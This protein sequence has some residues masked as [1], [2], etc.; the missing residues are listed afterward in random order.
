MQAIIDKKLLIRA[1]T[2]GTGFGRYLFLAEEVQHLLDSQRHEQDK[3]VAAMSVDEARLSLR[4]P[5]C[6]ISWVIKQKLLHAQ[7]RISS[8]RPAFII[9]ET[10]LV[11]FQQTYISAWHLAASINTRSYKLIPALRLHNVLPAT[12]PSSGLIG[13]RTFFRRADVI[14]L[15]LAEI[16]RGSPAI[17]QNKSRS[18]RTARVV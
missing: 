16:V 1:T 13:E 15:D 8:G 12:S 17:F 2:S 9:K 7:R 3:A 14:G 4:I 10:D 5:H 11:A 18:A 6:A